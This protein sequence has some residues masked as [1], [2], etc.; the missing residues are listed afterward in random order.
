MYT[1]VLTGWDP[2]TP[3]PPPHLDVLRGRYWSEKNDAISVKPRDLHEGR[4]VTGEVL[5]TQK[6]RSSTSKHEIFLLYFYESFLLSWIRIPNAD[7]DPVD[8]NQCSGSRTPGG[9]RI[10]T[11]NYLPYLVNLL[12]LIQNGK[13]L[14][15]HKALSRIRSLDWQA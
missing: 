8:Q 4:P 2:A 6:R 10:L 5:S 14:L 9:M 7:P 12:E 13:R 15:R 1:A 3:P 11:C